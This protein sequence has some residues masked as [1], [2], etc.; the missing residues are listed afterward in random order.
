MTI[1]K[2]GYGDTSGAWN[3]HAIIFSCP[4]EMTKVTVNN[5]IAVQAGATLNNVTINE[6][7]EY[8]GLWING[9]GQT[10][11]MNGGAINAPNAGR[12]IKIADQY[13]DTPTKVTLNVTGTAFT[14]AKKAAVLVSSKA[15]AKI[16][17][18]NVN[19]ENVVADNVNFVWVDEDWAANYGN[20]EVTGATVA[21]ESIES[22]VAAISKTQDGNTNI[23]EYY[24]TLPAAIAAVQAGEEITLL[25]DAQGA[26]IVIDKDVTIDFNGHAYTFSELG[27]G[28]GTL[29]SNGFQILKGN[30]VTLKNGTLNVAK[31]M[32]AEYYILVQNYANLTVENMKLDGT[33]LDKWSTTDGDSYVLS[34]N[35][36]NVNIVNTTITANN[37]GDKAFAFDVCKKESYTAPI[38]TLDALSKIK[39]KVELS[40]GQFYPEKGVTVSLTKI[41][42]S[43]QVAD[44]K[45][46]LESGWYTISAPFA[47]TPA[48]TEGY[49]LFRYNEAEAM[50]ENHK[51]QEHNTFGLQ[52]GRGY[53]YAHANGA[54]LNLKGEAN[55]KDY[56]TD[57]SYTTDATHE[58]KGFHLV[59]NPY[60]FS[61]SG[62]H[63]SGNV[64]DGFYTLANSGAWVVKQTADEIA[65]GEGFLVQAKSATK[66]AI[67][68]KATKTRSA[69][70]GSL[71]INVANAKYSDVAYVSFNEGVGLNKISHQNTNIPMVYV[72]VE[73][74]NYSI[75]YMNANVEEIPFAFEAKTMGSY[76]ISVEAQNCEFSTMTLI[77]R[78]TG[79]ETN[80]LF[81]D[82]SF[83]AK[84]SDNSNRFIIRLSQGTT[85]L[86]EEH[87][88]YINNNGLIINNASSNATLQIFDVM[89]RPVSSHNL[90]GNANIAVESLTNGVYILRLIDDNNVRV[91]KVVID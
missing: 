83:I 73:G 60:T 74:E 58:L 29:T 49:E 9:N 2:T 64:A 57:L 26:G 66:F 44:N 56:S 89:G 55:I 32:Q 5:G 78:F 67:N 52:V 62:N 20:V 91:Q 72:P 80:L 23:I 34:N 81:E 77:D 19:I 69:D 15:G 16:A 70:N 46:E 17:A 35:S 3:T 7:G 22:F 53:L 11:T 6:A 51:N 76:T 45:L 24:K 50:W 1:E 59:G 54:D 36:G 71:Q 27:V 87:F 48:L 25:R 79:I 10:V 39:G 14:T 13:I 68:K 28:S 40:G 8:Y 75:A 65:V 33:N 86:E 82:Y 4:L 84:S 42:E 38:V 85:D 90:S 61:I 30:N 47:V 37:D 63:F 21:Q 43:Y 41:V 18:S 12:G 88:A 31:E